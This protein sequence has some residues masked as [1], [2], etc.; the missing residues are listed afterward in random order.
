MN[1]KLKEFF[2]TKKEL[3]VFLALLVVTFVTVIAIAEVTVFQDDVVDAPSD[4]TTNDDLDD[5]TTND[6]LDDE[7]DD[8]TVEPEVIYEFMLPTLGNQ[9][10]I[11]TFFDSESPT[12]DSIIETNG[13]YLQSNGVSYASEDNSSFEVVS[14]YPGTVLS[15]EEDEV[16]GTT[17]TIDHGNDL[18]SVY[19]SLANSYVNEGDVVTSQQK[20]AE[21]SASAFDINAGVHVHVQIISESNYINF[22]SV[23]GK[24][25]DDVVASIK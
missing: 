17:I 3:L 14:V 2:Q 23:V 18:F 15:V 4:D 19:S 21:A 24:T 20:L 22:L 5:D 25:M 1:E 13:G 10:V 11:R 7:D 9:I 6:D 8:T 16:L 12:Q